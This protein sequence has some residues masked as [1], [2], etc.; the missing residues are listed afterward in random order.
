MA[1]RAGR[2]GLDK[3]GTVMICL[4]NDVPYESILKR[5]LTGTATK[6]SSQFRL[7]YNMILNLLRVNDLSVE[8]MIKRSFSEFHSQS[9]LS[10]HDLSTRLKKYELLLKK[11]E[12]QQAKEEESTNATEELENYVLEMQKSQQLLN[13]YLSSLY[14]M[15]GYSSDFVTSTI[16]KVGRVVF[17]HSGALPCPCLGVIITKPSRFSLT[18]KVKSPTPSTPMNSPTK[19]SNLQMN[20][21]L[22]ECWVVLLLPS[23]TSHKTNETNEDLASASDNQEFQEMLGFF[24]VNTQQLQTINEDNIHILNT[25]DNTGIAFCVKRVRVSE[26][27]LIS[28]L[29]IDVNVSLTNSNESIVLNS[30]KK[31]KKSDKQSQKQPSNANSSISN[32][33]L[34]LDDLNSLRSPTSKAS[35]DI[36]LTSNPILSSKQKNIILSKALSTLTILQLESYSSLSYYEFKDA[37]ISNDMTIIDKQNALIR[38]VAMIQSCK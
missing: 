21:V 20:E 19:G 23:L 26:I 10:K 22:L 13:D 33:K 35:M 30:S 28:S 32:V 27:A 2:R 4:W 24:N 36:E 1:G 31:I 14:V 17:V 3:V 38:S 37:K 11:L 7:S 5:L 12:S 18:S 15:K 16:L 9:A 29:V 34:S 8:D 25:Q 6:L